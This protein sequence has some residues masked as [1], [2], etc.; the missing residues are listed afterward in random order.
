MN[1]PHQLKAKTSTNTQKN[2]FKVSAKKTSSKPP[3]KDPPNSKAMEWKTL[4]AVSPTVQKL[5]ALLPDLKS[6]IE[7]QPTAKISQPRRRNDKSFSDD[8]VK[9][10]LCFAYSTLA[11]LEIRGITPNVNTKQDALE[12]F[13]VDKN[14]Y[15]MGGGSS[16][17]FMQLGISPI[18]IGIY[19]TDN[20][21]PTTPTGRGQNARNV[22]KLA[23]AQNL[24]LTA[25]L[26]WTTRTRSGNHWVY[27]V[28]AS[29]NNLYIR[30]QQNNHVGGVVNMNTWKGISEDNTFIYTITKVVVPRTKEIA[31]AASG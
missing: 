19:N 23:L 1:A 29:G 8:N 28:G 17:V 5:R 10:G 27:V 30:D 18:E 9:A 2:S 24:P 12:D 14:K 16:T 6:E 4:A 25:G 26:R 21:M 20:G 7:N 22:I 13:V 3:A 11:A 15:S 31:D